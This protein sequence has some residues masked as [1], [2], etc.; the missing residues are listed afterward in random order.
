MHR[1]FP[2]E[3][4]K[5]TKLTSRPEWWW[6]EEDDDEEEGLSP[7]PSSP[8]PVLATGIRSSRSLLEFAIIL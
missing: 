2:L 5:N 6:E 3:F 8:A 7:A 4:K 1:T